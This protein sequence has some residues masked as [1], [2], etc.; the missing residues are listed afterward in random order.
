MYNYSYMRSNHMW[1]LIDHPD[2]ITI[3]LQLLLSIKIFAK[4]NSTLLSLRSQSLFINLFAHSNS[5]NCSCLFYIL[6]YSYS[7]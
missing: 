7:E 3:A 4:F 5:I 1:I 2:E 6:Y